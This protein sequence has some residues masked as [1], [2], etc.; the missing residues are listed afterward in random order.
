MCKIGELKNGKSHCNFRKYLRWAREG[1]ER[2]ANWLYVMLDQFDYTYYPK[3]SNAIKD[4]D[5]FVEINNTDN[6]M[7]QIQG[8]ISL[9]KGIGKDK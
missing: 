5:A 1:K 6:D 9:R 8:W 2:G 7:Q 3:Y 4:F